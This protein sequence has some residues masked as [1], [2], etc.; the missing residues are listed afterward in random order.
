MSYITGQWQAAADSMTAAGSA[1]IVALYIARMDQLCSSSQTH[2]S[3]RHLSAILHGLVQICMSAERVFGNWQRLQA[4]DLELEPFLFRVLHQLQNVIPSVT[5][6]NASSILWSFAKL[7]INPDSLLPGIVDS[8]AQQFIHKQGHA[9]DQCY[10]NLMLATSELQLNPCKGQMLQVVVQGLSNTNLSAF[11]PQAI[12]NITYAFARLPTVTG[13]LQLLE[14]LCACFLHKLQSDVQRQ[15]PNSQDVANFAWALHKLRHEPSATLAAALLQRMQTL[16]NL[17]GQWP[18]PYHISSFLLACADLRVAVS[19]HQANILVTHLLASG[20]QPN[21]QDLAN[22][23]WALAVLGLLRVENFTLVLQS[24]YIASA[25][26]DLPN[27]AN[28]RQLYQAFDC[29]SNSDH[30]HGED[31]SALELQLAQ[32][33]PRPFPDEPPSQLTRELS[34]ALTVLGVQYN[35]RVV[36]RGCFLHAV[37]QPQSD[38]AGQI[39]ISVERAHYY[40]VNSPFR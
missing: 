1:E 15:Q 6:R 21:A 14:R 7:R 19:Q 25:S 28:L 9:T 34:A 18:L 24:L 29:L 38:S 33:G 10:A 17:Y 16:C 23:A 26:F 37:V 3:H 40:F 20:R 30:A 11:T 13:T 2:L 32:I 27:A 36:I 35:L 31:L 5:S 39:L 4:A 8:V 22:T 12:S